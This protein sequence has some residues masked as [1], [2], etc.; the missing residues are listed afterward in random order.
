MQRIP[1]AL[2]AVA[3]CLSLTLAC[4]KSNEPLSPTAPGSAA[5]ADGATLKA[6]APVP[7]SPISD[8]K[9]TGSGRPTL[10]ASAAKGT[11]GDPPFQYH[12]QVM[13]SG[14]ALVAESPLVSSTTWAVDRDLDGNTRY[15][16][17]VRAEYDGAASSWSAAQGF[18]TD[19]P[20]LINDPLTDGTTVGLRRG[21]NFIPGTGWQSTSLTD[22]IDY[23]IPGGCYDCKLEFDATNFGGQ[24]GLPFQ[25]D[26]KWVSMGD[27]NAF[28]GFSAFRDHPWKMHLV[29]RADYPTGM[30]IIWRNGGTNPNGGDPGD[31]RIKLLSTPITFSSSQTYH[32]QLD[33]GLFGYEIRVNG[34]EVLS[35]GW[36]HWY[37]LTNLRIELGC[38]PR[39]ESFVG[40]IYRN[41]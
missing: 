14:G 7:Q 19:D 4:T 26:L 32:F 31:H 1:V 18:I 20:A 30:E 41:G 22:G 27:A 37:E 13:N 36:D 17:R 33:W 5:T 28:G 15:T 24:E 29:Q 21:G 23:D 8:Q 11:F 25:K 2:T 6:T 35:D 16:W 34:I 10:T 9:L 39:A 3:A 12:F 38:I 40:V